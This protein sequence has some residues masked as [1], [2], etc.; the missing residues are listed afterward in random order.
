M[1]ESRTPSLLLAAALCGCLAGLAPAAAQQP[2]VKVAVVNVERIVG[3]SEA[4]KQ[5]QQ[6]LEAFQEQVRAELAQ[7][8]DAARAIQQ[9]LVTKG[10]A[11]SDEARSELEKRYEDKLIAI[12]RLRDDKQREGQK[13]Q[14]EAL[15]KIEQRLEPIFVEVRDEMDLDLILALTPGVVLM[16]NERIDLTD[17]I[18]E[19][20]N[21]AQTAGGG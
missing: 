4:G 9:E 17:V 3:V 7:E 20:F 5:L 21:A 11:L 19:R 10:N 15:K 18:I 2:Q 1:R 14:E 12:R 16:F 13:M 6:R 8:T